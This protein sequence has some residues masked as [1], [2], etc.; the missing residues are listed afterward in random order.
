MAEGPVLPGFGGASPV[1]GV[2]RRSCSQSLVG[3]LGRSGSITVLLPAMVSKGRY[4]LIPAWS[5]LE[6]G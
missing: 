6:Q 5:V 3:G 4:L 2:G 1:V